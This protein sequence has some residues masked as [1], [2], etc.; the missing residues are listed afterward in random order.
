M[1]GRQ[2]W[3]AVKAKGASPFWRW[4]TFSQRGLF[5]ITL[6]PRI[7]AFGG[8]SMFHGHALIALKAVMRLRFHRSSKLPP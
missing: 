2:P 3:T 4:T 1:N 6:S 5:P 7:H 8:R